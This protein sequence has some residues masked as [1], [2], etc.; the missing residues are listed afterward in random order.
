MTN[1][2]R[3]ATKAI[4][5]ILVLGVLAFVGIGVALRGKP[6]FAALQNDVRDHHG[7]Q[8]LN[9]FRNRAPERAADSFLT[10]LSSGDCSAVLT[11]L[12]EEPG[13]KQST[14]ESEQKYPMKGWRLEAIG[15]DG[16]RT[17]LRYG[18]SRDAG[19]RMAHDPFWIWVSKKD[20]QGYQVT[21]YEQWY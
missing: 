4:V 3:C 17:L 13:R 6:V 20:D 7:S 19:K 5:T 21:G 1:R 10:R 16:D 9:P 2:W 12:G 15:R 14:C 11:Q 18:V 8:V